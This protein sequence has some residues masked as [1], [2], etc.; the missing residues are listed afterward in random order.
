MVNGAA[1]M[2]RCMP[3]PKWRRLAV[4]VLYRKRVI[5]GLLFLNVV[6]FVGMYLM[7][8]ASE[9]NGFRDGG[10]MYDGLG[11]EVAVPDNRVVRDRVRHPGKDPVGVIDHFQKN[12]SRLSRP[13]VSLTEEFGWH[14]V[15][16][17]TFVY[18]AYFDNRTTT[19]FVLIWGISAGRYSDPD[20]MPANGAVLDPAIWNTFYFG[21]LSWCTIVRGLRC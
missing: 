10:A 3:V 1:Q 13:D 2:A 4:Y 18:S 16:D 17:G 15:T 6:F 14:K 12:C 11:A 9:E 21:V 19:D 7:T 8:S 20:W 5:F